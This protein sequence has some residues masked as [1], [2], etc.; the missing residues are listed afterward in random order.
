MQ[1]GPFRL[2][3]DDEG[4]GLVTF[5][6]RPVNAFSLDV[7]EALGELSDAVR[8]SDDVRVIVFSAPADARAWCGG[9]DVRE[10]VGMDTARRKERY[11]FINA[12]L[13]R[14]ASLDRP[15]IAAVNAHAVGVGTVLAGLCDLR[16]AADSATFACPEIDYGLVGGGAG[17]FSYLNLPEAVI[18]EMLYTGRR[19]SAAEMYRAGFLNYVVSREAVLGKALELARSMAEKSLPALKARK[20]VFLDIEGK[21]WHESYLLAQGASARLVA[22]QDAREGVEAFLEHRSAHLLDE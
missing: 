16:V 6:R 17:L 22:G 12:S 20:Q 14:F 4:V 21:T 8:S 7:Y 3:C 11:E 9:A 15:V 1:F 19:F 10:F 2:E 13:P 18:R 5:D